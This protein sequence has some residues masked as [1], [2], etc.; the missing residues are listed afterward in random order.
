MSNLV[1]ITTHR[2]DDECAECGEPIAYGEAAYYEVGSHQTHTGRT[3]YCED[4]G[5]TKTD[6]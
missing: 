4:C 3:T 2:K 5:K 6:G 1:P